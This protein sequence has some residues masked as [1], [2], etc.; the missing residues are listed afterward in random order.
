M[1]RQLLLFTLIVAGGL[2]IGG[3]ADA[4]TLPEQLTVEGQ[5]W[6]KRGEGTATYLWFRVY[7]AA[8]YAP[9]PIEQSQALDANTA[10]ALVL[11]YRQTISAEDIRKAS[12]QVLARQ[13]SQA[14]LAA[15]K[16]A[17]DAL[18]SSMQGVRPGDQYTLIWQPPRLILRFNQKTVFSRDDSALAKAYFGIWLGTAPLSDSLKTEL[19]SQAARASTQ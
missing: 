18:E 7:D 15:L 1:M 19:L 9:K 16:P 8:L 3:R 17:L 2:G 6:Q 4:A 10:R 12:N 14:A 13:Q 5:S 11:H